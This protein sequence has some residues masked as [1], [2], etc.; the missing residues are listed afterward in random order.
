MELP[1]TPKLIR[2]LKTAMNEAH[3]EW[4]N[5]SSRST[6][7]G[8]RDL[9]RRIWEIGFE[10]P[11]VYPMA[12]ELGDG[13]EAHSREAR[14]AG[15]WAPAEEHSTLKEFKYDVVWSEHAAE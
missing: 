5:A 6:E 8:T 11:R 9:K 15:S 12:H 10:F 7:L 3:Q 13:A 4:E 2:R 1:A 14:S